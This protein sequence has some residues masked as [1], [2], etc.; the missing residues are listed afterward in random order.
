MSVNDFW[1]FWNFRYHRKNWQLTTLLGLFVAMK[2]YMFLKKI[3]QTKAKKFKMIF[4]IKGRS[5]MRNISIISLLLMLIIDT[6]STRVDILT[7]YQVLNF[8]DINACI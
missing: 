6:M 4:L 2:F 3:I 5:R 1:N 7:R 8:D